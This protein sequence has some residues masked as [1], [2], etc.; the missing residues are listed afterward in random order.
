M[1]EMSLSSQFDL[2]FNDISMLRASAVSGN[3][4]ST[5]FRFLAWM[6]FLECIPMDKNKWIASINKNRKIYERIKQEFHCNPREES[7]E[8]K[9]VDHPLSSDDD[10][11]WKKYFDHI[12]LKSVIIQDV[13]RLWVLFH[14]FIYEMNQK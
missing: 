9:N 7:A 10:S 2:L 14:F 3:L 8:Q 5:S 11:S 13:I 12:E 4:G 6:I 1:A